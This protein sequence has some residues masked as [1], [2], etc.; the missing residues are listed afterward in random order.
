VPAATDGIGERQDAE[1]AD[2]DQ[3]RPSDAAAE[4]VGQ[5]ALPAERTEPAPGLE[6][7]LHRD[8]EQGGHDRRGSCARP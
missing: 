1:P 4:R 5:G 8:P 6:R 3:Q 2:Q 7:R